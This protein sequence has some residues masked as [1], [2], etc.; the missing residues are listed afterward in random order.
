MRIRA[1]IGSRTKAFV[2][3][4]SQRRRCRRKQSLKLRLNDE[5]NRLYIN[6]SAVHKS[7]CDTKENGEIKGREREKKVFRLQIVDSFDTKYFFKRQAT[8][9][10]IYIYICNLCSVALEDTMEMSLPMTFLLCY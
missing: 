5:N 1:W 6:T 2:F 4:K 7:P 10:P 9:H 8:K 3:E